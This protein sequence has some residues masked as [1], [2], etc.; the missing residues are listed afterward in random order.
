MT[1][2]ELTQA[3][4]QAIY[5]LIVFSSTHISTGDEP[6]ITE[7]IDKFQCILDNNQE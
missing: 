5:N 7:L 4:I 1:T 6:L 2:I 3:E